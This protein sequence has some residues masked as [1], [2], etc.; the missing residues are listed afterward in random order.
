MKKFVK[1]LRIVAGLVAESAS[2]AFFSIKSDKLRTFLSLFGV[3]VGIFSIVA[4]FCAVD[5]LKANIMEGVRSFGSEVVYIDRFPMSRQED[6]ERLQWWDYLQRPEVSEE[7]FEYV[8]RN[9]SLSETVVYMSIGSGH[10][11]YGRRKCSNTC[12]LVTTDGLEDVLG[13]SIDEGRNFTSVEAR[14]GSSVVVLG[15][16]VAQELFGD[17]YPVGHRIRVRG[18]SATVVGVLGKQGESLASVVDTD[19]AVILPLQYG[20]TVLASSWGAGMM[21]AAPGQNVPRQEFLDELRLLMRSCRRLT[22]SEE[23]NFSVNEMTMLLDMLDD[24]FAG[25][26]RAGWIIGAFSLLIGGFGIANI[27]FVSVQER[28]GQTG[29]QRALGARRYVILV[30]FLVEAI[31]LSLA[32]GLIGILLVFFVSIPVNAL[33]GSF[34]VTV[35]V[36]NAVAGMAISMVIGLLSGIIPAWKAALLDPVRAISA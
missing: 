24:V 1:E 33:S 30:Q 8:A 31:I 20:K 35:S 19:N 3:T 17:Q 23:D 15:Y 10:V 13:I 5:S 12:L 29:I 11:S 9:A 4:V 25:I 14:G 28:I 22:P 6:G 21:L 34:T 16:E 32:G 2:F 7:D 27:M 18:S 26:S 36:G